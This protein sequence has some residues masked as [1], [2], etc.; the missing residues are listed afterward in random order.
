MISLRGLSRT[1]IVFIQI[2]ILIEHTWQQNTDSR[3]ER[4]EQLNYTAWVSV[5]STLAGGEKPV[6][7]GDAALP[8]MTG[9][10][11]HDLKLEFWVLPYCVP[12][13]WNLKQPTWA[14]NSLKLL[15]PLPYDIQSLHLAFPTSLSTE[16][17]NFP[18][19]NQFSWLCCISYYS[20][21]HLVGTQTFVELMIMVILH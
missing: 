8:W 11:S 16:H 5:T 21:Y 20:A 1:Q 14:V 2:S 13:T 15:T 7:D 12:Q 4:K 9:S 19:E 18:F 6:G 17:P 10:R 3:T